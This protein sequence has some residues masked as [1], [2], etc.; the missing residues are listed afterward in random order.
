MGNAM[1]IVEYTVGAQSI[2]RFLKKNIFLRQNI[3]GHVL[4][5]SL[6]CGELAVVMIVMVQLIP[7]RSRRGAARST[8][9]FFNHKCYTI[10]SFLRNENMKTD[11]SFF[12]IY[13]AN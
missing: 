1:E 4:T 5:I 6:L 11:W 7:R 13:Q 3:L 2:I 8:D 10:N 12:C 9:V